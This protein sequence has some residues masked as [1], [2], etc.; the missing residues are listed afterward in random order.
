M[1]LLIF[2]PQLRSFV[3]KPVFDLVSAQ[4]AHDRRKEMDRSTRRE[5]LF[6]LARSNPLFCRSARGEQ[7]RWHA[8]F[9][10]GTSCFGELPA[11]FDGVYKFIA[12]NRAVSHM[13]HYDDKSPKKALGMFR[14]RIHRVR[15]H[16]AVIAWSDLVLDHSRK[17]TGL[18]ARRLR[19]WRQRPDYT[20]KRRTRGPVLITSRTAASSTPSF[21][22]PEWWANRTPMS[23]VGFSDKARGCACWLCC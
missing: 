23:G 12:R 8:L 22:T 10:L 21:Q 16:A 2:L 15:G 7:A 17:L 3:L 6:W 20:R 1:P 18:H 4:G 14:S 11:G 13:D 19:G 5:G 9:G